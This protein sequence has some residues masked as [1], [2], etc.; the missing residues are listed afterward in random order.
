MVILEF[1]VLASMLA[2]STGE[3]QP[4]EGDTVTQYTVLPG[5]T[6]ESLTRKFLGDTSLWPENQRLNPQVTNP[7]RLRIGSTL[8]II[9]ARLPVAR[10]A[11]VV[12]VTRRVEEKPSTADWRPARRG[13]VLQEKE[14]L[15]TGKDS[16][17]ALQFDDGTRMSLGED[18]LVFLREATSTATGRKKQSLEVMEGQ[19]DLKSRVPRN[20]P[21]SDIQILVG[22]AVLRPTADVKGEGAVR[23]RRRAEG[24]AEVMVFGG[25][26]RVEAAGV[27]VAVGQGMGTSIPKGQAP[28]PPERLLSRPILESPPPNHKSAYANPGLAWKPVAAAGSYTAEV[29]ED[30]G[31]EKLAQR[32]TG[33]KEP[34][35]RVPRLPLGTYYWRAMGVSPGGLD[36]YPSSAS[37]LD[38]TSDAID[39]EPPHTVAQIHAGWLLGADKATRAA[40]GEW[41]AIEGRDD[42][43][44]LR[45]LRIRWDGGAWQTA[46]AAAMS[47]CEDRC[48]LG[49]LHSRVILS[50][51]PSGSKV[52]VFEY[53]AVDV[54]GQESE[55]KSLHIQNGGIVPAPPGGD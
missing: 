23:A 19:A 9:T 35:Y 16:S 39:S 52:H 15:R 2:Q 32:V 54:A 50:R 43:S 49:R 45:E 8:R 4:R 12:L 26:S 44:G 28:K 53:Q 42:V 25:A 33:L 31:C 46:P 27:S 55:R 30:P 10:T 47:V 29:C 11:E 37:R 5:D 6:L 20:A 14:G 36:G 7:R 17:S 51:I 18:S 34:R 3:V 41:V 24:G 21:R 1:V 13:S 22:Q 38:I 48:L 40:A